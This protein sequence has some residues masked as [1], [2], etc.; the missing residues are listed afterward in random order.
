MNFALDEQQRQLRDTAR[1][2]LSAHAGSAEVRAAMATE[3]GFDPALWRRIAEEMGWPAVVV[4]ED[5]G[6]L[7]LG[8]V[9]I[10]VLMEAMGAAVLCAPFFSTV[11]LGANALVVGASPEQRAAWL[12]GI[13]A[14]TTTAALAHAEPDGRWDAD[15]V[16]ALARI[17]GANVVLSGTKAYVVDGHTADLLLVA[18]RTPGTSGTTGVALYLVPATTPGLRRRA[19][20]TLDQTRRLA[21]IVLDDVRVPRSAVLGG[22]PQGWEPL[23][24]TLRLAT[25]ALAAEQVGG[26]ERC[27]DLAVAY[28]GERM[29]FG[30]PIGSFQAIKHKCADMLMRVE[31]ARSATYYAACAADERGPELAIAASLAKAYASDTYFRCAADCLQIH[32]GVGFTWEY[33]VHLYFKRARSSESLLGDAQYHRELVARH[34]AL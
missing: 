25:V 13:A 19:L 21:E 1:A 3:R 9:E 22:D 24:T 28:A 31:A 32:G 11:C 7:G 14:G 2:F 17:D 23:A 18:A 26:A 27:L 34:L 5:Y 8:Q 30:R 20:A 6:G 4:P 29:Q 33:D 12:P 15:G 16:Q 10:M